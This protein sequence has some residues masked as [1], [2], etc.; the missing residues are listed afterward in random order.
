VVA[1]GK[2]RDNFP[3]RASRHSD[4]PVVISLHKRE[5]RA[6]TVARAILHDIREDRLVAG[7]RL[8]PEVTMLER[9]QVARGTLREALRILEVQSLI[10]IRHGRDGGPVVNDP[11]PRD[12]SHVLTLFL[13]GM[14]VT[15]QDLLDARQSVEPVM[16]RLAAASDDQE[17]RDDLADILKRTEKATGWE[18]IATATADFHRRILTMS[19]NPV[20]DLWAATLQQTV[21]YREGPPMPKPAIE[22]LRDEHLAI[23]NAILDHD[24]E[25]AAQLM[26]DHME[27]IDGRTRGQ[28][29]FLRQRIEWR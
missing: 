22:S 3:P 29:E 28:A 18:E 11:T 5:K 8:P 2:P 20:L 1:R 26:A 15:M 25:S 12:F 21:D 17:K 9:Y 10:T 14:D 16:A 23:G 24:G 13:Q 6:V 7:D 4:A 27:Q 19:G